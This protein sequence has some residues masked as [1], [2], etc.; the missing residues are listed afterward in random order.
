MLY[1][2]LSPLTSIPSLLP[3][4]LGFLQVMF[5]NSKARVTLPFSHQLGCSPKSLL[6]SPSFYLLKVTYKPLKFRRHVPKKI[7][8]TQA[9]WRKK[10]EDNDSSTHK[11]EGV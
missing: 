1:P 11:N 6:P 5:K 10:K 3:R 9:K 4:L 8:S 2:K 7:V